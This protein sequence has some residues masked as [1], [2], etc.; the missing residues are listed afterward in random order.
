MSLDKA[1]TGDRLSF[2]VFLAIAVH[3]M[4]ILGVSFGINHSQKAAPTLNI[5][6]ATYQADKAPEEADYLA[7]HNQEASGTID[8]AKELT[9]REYAEIAAPSIHEV[10]PAP[11]RKSTLQSQSEQQFVSASNSDFKI[12]SPVKTDDTDFDETLEAEEED[13]PLINPEIASLRAKLDRMKQEFSKRPRIRRMT[14]VATKSSADAEYLNKWTQ[15]VEAMGNHH[16]PQAAI[17]QR[18][19]GSLRLSVLINDD[20]SVEKVEILKPSGFPILDQAALQTIRLAAPFEPF[21]AEIRKNAE[22]LDIIRTWRFE[23]TGLRTGG[24]AD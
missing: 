24:A 12:R 11:H 8:E 5:T 10:N 13:S 14:S 3:A 7:Q 23:I 18:I 9:A 16:F 19:F 2:T 22:Q 4:I 1:S 21:P 6:L 15:K 20:G 17:D